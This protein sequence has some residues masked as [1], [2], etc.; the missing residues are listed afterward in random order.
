[1]AGL[2][3]AGGAGAGVEAPP[4]PQR[5][6]TYGPQGGDGDVAGTTARFHACRSRCHHNDEMTR[7]NPAPPAC[8]PP[9]GSV[10]RRLMPPPGPALPLRRAGPG[11]HDGKRPRPG[12]ERPRDEPGEDHPCMPP[13]IGGIAGGRPH[14]IALPA[15]ATH[16]GARVL[17]ERLVASQEDWSRR[18]PLVPPER[19]Q[20]ARQ[21]P[22]RP[23]ALGPH[24]RLGSPRPLS[25]LAHG[26]S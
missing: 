15:L 8:Q 14:P 13:A 10:C 16:L 25:L 21:R 20:R 6:K 11:D 5:Q 24:P 9:P 22:R 1:V 23:S 7:R 18:D 12:S 2:G 4:R 19:E 3:R 17:S 26:T